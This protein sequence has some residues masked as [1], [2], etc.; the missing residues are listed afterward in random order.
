MRQSAKN[1][2][3]RFRA[4]CS[5]ALDRDPCVFTLALALLFTLILEVMNQRSP[6]AALRF[7]AG[8]P[9]AFLANWVVLW[10]YLS[11]CAFIRR[12]VFLLTLTSAVWLMLGLA[13]FI[14]Q[15]YRASP[16]GAIDIV[17]LRHQ[18]S[19][20]GIYLKTWEIVLIAL[21][22]LGVLAGLTVLFIRAR[23]MSV[24]LFR[25][26]L[27]AVGALALAVTAVVLMMNAARRE[28][29]WSNLAEAYRRYGFAC[30][31]T[32]TVFDR[33][34]D[35]PE[36]YSPEEVTE[37]VSELG[38]DEMEEDAGANV[39]LVQLESFFDVNYITNLTYSENPVPVFTELEETC[40]GGLLTV[41]VLGA[42]TANT[43]F[44]VLTG[45]STAFFGAGEYP[46]KTIM[47]EETCETIAYD[48]AREG[49]GTHAIH[50]NAGT[51]YD[52]NLV[53]EQMGFD[54]FTSIEYMKN[55]EYNP[56]GWAR[57]AILT[58]EIIKALDSTPGHDLVFTVTVQGHGKYQIDA[59][60]EIPITVSGIEDE[61]MKGS[62]EYF[63]SQLKET[64]EF[65]GDLLARLETRKERTI[66][67]LYGDHLPNFVFDPANFK[68][69]NLYQ[70][71]YVIWNNYGLEAEGGDICAYQLS[72][73]IM[74]MIG[75]NGG[76]I[77][78]FHRERAGDPDYLDDLELLEYDVL[79]GDRTSYGGENPYM[80][81]GMRMGTEEIRIDNV[82]YA[83]GLLV[84]EGSGFT[85][86]SVITVD[87]DECDTRLTGTKL[88]SEVREPESGE[89]IAVEQIGGDKTTLSVTAPWIYG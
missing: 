13:N 48:M 66:V 57:D 72:T 29:G 70:T 88:V 28:N 25:C 40:P 51:F 46:Y 67:V 10:A 42:G 12:R 19:I 74:D 15:C 39:V 87:G 61:E 33:G 50:N 78:Q 47:Q 43:E 79:Y 59:L 56:I 7:I 20:L 49:Y 26:V 81:K 76:V 64:D 83:G 34:I 58:D 68:N 35:E 84:V 24:T 73:R 65:I 6:A 45:M 2:I 75:V 22:I 11:L 4:F 37:I 69:G 77:T 27:P 32:Q 89:E 53:Y 14:A 17:L 8:H 62:F 23:K 5:R 55:V 54:T 63:L 52:R 31:F 86:W 82:W 60:D 21:G 85:D 41:P 80:P 71:E 18:F 38:N 9:L 44:E 30:S 16:I 36:E 1:T 3:E